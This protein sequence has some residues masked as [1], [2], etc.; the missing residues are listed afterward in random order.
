[1]TAAL[2]THFAQIAARYLPH[3]EL[4]DYGS[5]A[6]PDVP[7]GSSRELAYLLGQVRH[8]LCKIPPDQSS[9][10]RLNYDKGQQSVWLTSWPRLVW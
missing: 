7:S 2:M 3:W 6:K 8:P 9:W 4:L 1:M 5:E 10:T